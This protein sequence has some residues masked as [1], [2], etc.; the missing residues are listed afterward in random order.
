MNNINLDKGFLESRYES[1][2]ERNP[3]K[4]VGNF[5]GRVVTVLYDH[6]K[7]IVKALMAA[8]L[9]ATVALFLLAGFSRLRHHSVSHVIGQLV[10]LI[11]L[12]ILFGSLNAYGI[13]HAMNLIVGDVNIT[14]CGKLLKEG[15]KK[16]QALYERATEMLHRREPKKDT[17]SKNL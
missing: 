7:E 17:A 4:V 1:L 8:C 5:A 12:G 10:G 3:I 11:A 2:S 16:I 6:R 15:D 14:A 9:C 13:R